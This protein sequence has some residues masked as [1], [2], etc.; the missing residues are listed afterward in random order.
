[1]VETPECGRWI[2]NTVAYG[3]PHTTDDFCVLCPGECFSGVGVPEREHA[4]ARCLQGL[5]VARERGSL[6]LNRTRLTR[7]RCLTRLRPDL[8]LHSRRH[9]CRNSAG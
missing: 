8:H 2:L 5:G 7:L 3:N 1:M 9:R 4:R 6:R